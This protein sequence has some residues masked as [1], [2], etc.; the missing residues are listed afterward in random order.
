MI[1]H[2]MDLVGGDLLVE[3]AGE[4]RKEVQEVEEV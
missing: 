3:V 1:V 2:W 4:E